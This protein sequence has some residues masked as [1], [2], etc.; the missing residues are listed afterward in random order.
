MGDILPADC[1]VRASQLANEIELVRREMGRPTEGRMPVTV[2]G[3][4]PRECWFQALA[5]FRKVDRL[6][7]E[8]A[9]DP[10]ASVPHAPPLTDLHPAHVLQVIDAAMREV[11]EV[12]RALNIS[13]KAESPGRDV[14][15]APSDVYGQLATLNRQ[16]NLLLTQP[17]TPAD[18]FQQVSL[19]VAY[20]ARLGAEA[21][22]T[23]FQ[24]GKRPADCYDRL[25]ACLEL[26]RGLVRKSNHPVI[27]VAPRAG[28]PGGVVPS[29]VYDLA[30]LVLGEV[31]YLHAL[32]KDAPAPYPFEGNSPGRKLPSHVWQLAGTLEQQLTQL[33]R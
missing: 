10:P 15:K 6:C 19:A 17:F 21:K 18:V 33:G 30:S 16:T 7:A 14:Q 13:E 24:R 1:F 31:A 22:E 12:K 28:E 4:S 26:A 32:R 23:P 25:T 9:G 3:A 11:T 8:I 20:A 5:V 2:T 29:D 27:D